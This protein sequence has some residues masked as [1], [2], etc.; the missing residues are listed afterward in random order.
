M[1]LRNNLVFGILLVSSIFF[2]IGLTGCISQNKELESWV[3]KSGLEIIE[4]WGKPDSINTFNN[5]EKIYTWIDL[6]T[7]QYGPY[8]C[9]K[10]I[11]I[12][13]KHTITKGSSR[14][15]PSVTAYAQ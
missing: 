3:G 14:G 5:G 10:S 9:Q 13:N 2:L 11:T 6:G 1:Q 15:C 8:T 7:N 4:Q 12:N